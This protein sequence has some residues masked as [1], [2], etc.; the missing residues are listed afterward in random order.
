MHAE[1]PCLLG[2]FALHQ[3]CIEVIDS[4]P[5]KGKCMDP[6]TLG[7]RNHVF[8][9]PMPQAQGPAAMQ[10]DERCGMSGE[11]WFTFSCTGPQSK[12]P[13]ASTSARSAAVK[14]HVYGTCFISSI[15][16]DSN[17]HCGNRYHVSRSR[18][19]PFRPRPVDR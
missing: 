3:M 14:R 4:C 2:M 15:F 7:V 6:C 5:L 16:Q 8:L 11:A 13:F 19:S 17:A 9:P 18:A 1:S 10:P 12:Y